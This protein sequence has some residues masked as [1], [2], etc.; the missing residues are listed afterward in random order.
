M[1][2][3]TPQKWLKGCFP[4][5]YV[6]LIWEHSIRWCSASISFDTIVCWTRDA[7]GTSSFCTTIFFMSDETTP[8]PRTHILCFD[9]TS[10]EYSSE[11]T[12]IVKFFALLK[13]DNFDDQL[14]YYQVSIGTYFSPGVV[15][16]VFQWCAKILD[17]AFAWYLDAHV[18]Q[19][20]EFL[21]QNYKTGDKICL[22]GFSRGAYTARAL[23]GMLYKVGLLPRDNQQQIPFAYKLY[24]RTDKASVTLSAGFKQT[25]CQSVGIDFIGVWETVASVG[26]LATKTLPFT[27]DN[28]S[29]KTFRQALSLDEH[30][31]RFKPNLFHRIPSDASGTAP[32]ASA[33]P[34]ASDPESQITPL[35]MKRALSDYFRKIKM[36]KPK[37]Q[38]AE[39]KVVVQPVFE[40][41]VLEVWFS[42][43]HGDIGGGSVPNATKQALADI[44]LRWMIRQIMES[45]CGIQFNE[46]GLMELEIPFEAIPAAIPSKPEVP[47]T[48]SNTDSTGSSSVPS[49]WRALDALDAVQPLHDALV[50]DPAWWL[51]EILP[52]E[53][54]YQDANCAWHTS[55]AWNLGRGRQIYIPNPLFHVTVK[56]R[57]ADK[58]LAYTP[59]AQ[60]QGTPVYVE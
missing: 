59:K 3:M 4:A 33:S 22:F 50:A 49:S 27:S 26:V 38:Q 34:K 55:Y 25:Y 28:T 52:M 37:L 41:D 20:Y 35:P 5:K 6:L 18:M 8:K 51:L 56:T 36:K 44:P 2:H 57:I 16:P 12:N 47:S 11:N 7:A 30:R 19:G 32:A 60:W 39:V 15:S 31:C 17:E 24:T 40:T 43:C 10:E 1:H 53:S 9:G 46:A 48:G 23:A 21:M 42:G 14:C 13:K 29:I 58:A 45:Q 54:K